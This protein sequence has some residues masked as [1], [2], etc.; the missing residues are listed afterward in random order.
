MPA[1]RMAALTPSATFS[2]MAGRP[3][4]SGRS[5][6]L[7]AVPM[8]EREFDCGPVLPLRANT[9]ACGVM[10][11]SHP[12]DHTMG[13]RAT[14]ASPRRPDFNR[15]RRNA[16]SA[17]MRVK[18]LT[19][20]LPSVLPM[21]AITS[22]AV[23][24]PPAMHAS[25]PAA[26]WTVLSSIFTTSIAILCCSSSHAGRTRAAQ[27]LFVPRSPVDHRK[28]RGTPGAQCGAHR[29]GGRLVDVAG[30]AGCIHEHHAIVVARRRAR[31]LALDHVAP[32]QLRLALERIAPAA[33]AGRHD[34]HHL[35]RAHRLAVDEAAEIPRSAFDIDRHAE[36]LARLSAVDPVAAEPHAIGG[37][38]G[39]AVDQCPVV[40]LIA[41]AAAPAAGAAGIRAQGNL[42]HPQREPRLGEFD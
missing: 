9:V 30:L 38:D 15:T 33:A 14:S 37:N 2:T 29:R 5:S 34:P 7:M 1:S 6:A 18:S 12:P 28:R 22:S 26:S 19:P 41:E 31:N 40:L 11:P 4:S 35:A 21:T 13:M 36:R 25:N 10:T 23:N 39:A 42:L 8:V 3:M 16:W 20:P 17:R 27:H 32:H 24:C